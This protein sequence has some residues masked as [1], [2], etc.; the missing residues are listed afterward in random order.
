MSNIKLFIKDILFVSKLTGTSKKKLR[1]A[2]SILFL[3]LAFG[4]DLI[5]IVIIANLFQSSNY[6]D[7]FIIQYFLNNLYWLPIIVI[8]RQIFAY[9]DVLNTFSLK[10]DVEESLRA[11]L[12]G[13]VFDKGNFSIADAYHFMNAF[14]MSV[15]AFYHSLTAFLASAIQLALYAGY[16]IYVDFQTL[17]VLIVGVLVLYLPTKILTKKGRLFAHIKFVAAQEYSEQLQKILENIFLIKLLKKVDEEKKQFRKFLHKLN[18]AELDNQKVGTVNTSFP[19]FATYFLLSV[20]LAFFNFA[21]VLTLDFIGILVR[22]FQEFSKLN[23]NIMLVSNNHVVIKKLHQLEKNKL[24]NFSS[25]FKVN[26][27]NKEGIVFKNVS[28]EYF[29]AENR[30]FED[31]NFT[32][33]KG[34]HTVLTGPNGSGKSTLLGLSSG[35]L[36]PQTGKIESFSNKFGYVGVTPLIISGSLREN[37]LYGNDESISDDKLQE[38]IEKFQ[39]FNEKSTDILEKKV[40]SKTLSSG[41]LQKVSFIRSLLSNVDILLLDESTSN[42]DENSRKLIFDILNSSNFTIL[43]C[44]HNHQDFE[45]DEHLKI[46]IKNEKRII[47]PL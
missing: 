43:N 34:K 20:L 3:F 41:Q 9:L 15:G 47:Q 22:L 31:L 27:N 12:I 44:T 1:I 4:S 13:E 46:Q 26:K 7:F 33:K 5:I 19:T 8:F 35:L 29:D 23:K 40:S 36:F 14:A 28:F 38:Y 6:S 2:L 42:L 45:Y 39:V 24:N 32:I 30:I 37:L 11:Y 21:K 17:G 16:L 10:F 25:N 18:K